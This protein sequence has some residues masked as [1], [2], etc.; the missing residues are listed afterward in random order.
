MFLFDTI[1]V[2]YFFKKFLNNISPPL[3]WDFIVFLYRKLS[4]K[5]N[6]DRYYQKDF[7]DNIDF[8][9]LYYA[10]DNQVFNVPASKIRNHGGQAYNQYQ[11]HFI[12]YY[13][14]GIGALK[15]FYIMKNA[16]KLFTLDAIPMVIRLK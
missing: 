14:D 10:F 4:G 5:A 9:S 7:S 1:H 2:M 12:Q 11:H 3:L 15:N 6:K 13:Q 16:Y 8:E